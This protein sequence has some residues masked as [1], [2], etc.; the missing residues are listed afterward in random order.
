LIANHIIF[1]AYGFWLPNDPRGSWSTF[2]G[3]WELFR[4]G[5]AMKTTETR[6]VAHRP[7]DFRQ[8]VAAKAVLKRPA[9][10][11]SSAQIEAVAMGFGE[12]AR[13][14]GLVIHAC[15]VLSD[16]VHLVTANHRLEP[17]KLVIQLKG[18]ATEELRERGIH[19]FGDNNK[20]F[21]RGE[22]VVFL[23]T[24]SD[25]HRAIQYVEQNPEK[26]GMPRQQ[27]AFVTPLS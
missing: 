4:F 19:P 25:V 20:A 22:W 12:Y 3:S 26:E 16:H 10:Q 14:S 6:S 11:F 8:R 9:V 1:G 21:A 15:A 2:V 24:P 23:D 7:H 27:W 13:R 18:S 5:A 17:H